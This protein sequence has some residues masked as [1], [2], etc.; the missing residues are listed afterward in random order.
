M[1]NVYIRLKD[2]RNRVVAKV[3]VGRTKT[4]VDAY[5]AAKDFNNT[6]TVHRS[7]SIQRVID[8]IKHLFP[9]NDL[10]AEAYAGNAPS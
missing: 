10:T 2:S 9:E 7:P 6:P 4:F 8:S 1:F 3:L 5:T